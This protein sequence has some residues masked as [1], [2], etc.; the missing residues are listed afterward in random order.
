M[1]LAFWKRDYKTVFIKSSP[2]VRNLT[3]TK[4]LGEVTEKGNMLINGLT[5]LNDKLA[6]TFVK[7]NIYSQQEEK[8]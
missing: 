3:T 7:T 1:R 2:C 4:F 6:H 8:A 5:V